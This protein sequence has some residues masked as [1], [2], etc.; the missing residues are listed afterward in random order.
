[1]K[2]IDIILFLQE[3]SDAQRTLS[4]RKGDLERENPVIVTA[5]RSSQN[6]GSTNMSSSDI[7]QPSK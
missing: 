6:G 4:R 5:I 3:Y 7:R 2:Y 1:M